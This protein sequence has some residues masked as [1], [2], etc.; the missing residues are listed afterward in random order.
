MPKY[1]YCDERGKF[2]SGVRIALWEK[3][4]S[5]G[6]KKKNNKQTNKKQNK[7]PATKVSNFQEAAGD[8]RVPVRNKER[9]FSQPCT[10]RPSELNDSA[11]HVPK[12]LS[13]FVYTL[14]TGRV[15]IRQRV[16][17]LIK[18][19]SQDFQS[20]WSNQRKDLTKIHLVNNSNPPSKQFLPSAL[21]KLSQI[22]WSQCLYKIVMVM[23]FLFPSLL[24]YV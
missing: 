9:N 7:G 13:G 22:T 1:K 10:P 20:I 17:Q 15:K 21:L 5:Y 6:R 23:A 14:L 4:Y 3:L 2:K 19:S 8:I 11:I 18:S 24:Q 12:K 16:D